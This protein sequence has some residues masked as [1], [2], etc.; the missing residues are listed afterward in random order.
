MSGWVVR[1]ALMRASL[2]VS[3]GGLLVS[4]RVLELFPVVGGKF[5]AAV[6]NASPRG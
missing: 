2:L 1:M 3:G 4:V 5:F 6:V